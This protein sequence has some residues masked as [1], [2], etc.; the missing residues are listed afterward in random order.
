MAGMSTE[1]LSSGLGQSSC[2]PE[3]QALRKHLKACIETKEGNKGKEEEEERKVSGAGKGC[4]RPL[5][6]PGWGPRT[7]V[8]LSL[9][10]LTSTGQSARFFFCFQGLPGLK[11]CDLYT[12]KSYNRLLGDQSSGPALYVAP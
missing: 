12:N 10:G 1:I 11:N 8:L 9:S 3:S 4:S 2:S 6:T 5:C 7:L